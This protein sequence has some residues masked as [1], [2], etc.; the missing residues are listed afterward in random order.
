VAKAL[1]YVAIGYVVLV[2][3]P[4]LLYAGPTGLFSL[5][6]IAVIVGLW[7]FSRTRPTA[8]VDTSFELEARRSRRSLPVRQRLPDPRRVRLAERAEE[9]ER[10]LPEDPLESAALQRVVSLALDERPEERSRLEDE[11][12]EQRRRFLAWRKEL[13]AGRDLARLEAEVDRIDAYLTGLRDLAA[14]DDLVSVALDG[15]GRASTALDEARGAGAHVKA[16][17][18][19][20]A[21]LAEARTCF[22][23]DEEQPLRALRL[24]GQAEAEAREAARKARKLADLPEQLERRLA[25]LGRTEER[26]GRDLADVKEDFSTAAQTYA[27]SC[28]LEIRGF[29]AAAEQA[30]ER[31]ARCRRSAEPQLA[32]GDPE[33]LGRVQDELDDGFRSLERAASLARKIAAHLSRLEEAAL[34]ARNDVSSVEQEIERA[35]AAS[36]ADGRG[37]RE[38]LARARDL[39]AQARAEL[40]REKPDWLAVR[41]L[42]Q[43]A[44]ALAQ[45]SA[46]RIEEPRREGPELT[47]LRE[48]L[49]AEKETA[50]AARDEAWAHALVSAEVQAAAT[51]LL[52][53]A[54]K[55]YQAALA[56]ER[57]VVDGD[58]AAERERLDTAIEAFR[59]AH[60]R[61]V[62]AR[63]EVGSLYARSLQPKYRSA[64]G[65]ARSSSYQADLIVWGSVSGADARLAD[66]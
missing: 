9:L 5:V 49:E 34:N 14:A 23:K 38:P 58:P 53:A 66:D 61:A 43:R 35:W 37:N 55:A 47:V 64:G 17:E 31:A 57:T 15:M 65:A 8:D 59:H 63:E 25:E 26:V 33:S 42:V 4:M 48:A 54:E 1:K 19:A 50:K 24:A 45:G 56:R 20:E 52:D 51:P 46:G 62:V 36:F 41:D 28:W 7:W 30:L 16:L 6:V 44:E 11:Y 13:D 39:A 2:V 40:E 12:R 10:E 22:E 21:K 3:L 18:A 29:G 27:R 32:A 60:T